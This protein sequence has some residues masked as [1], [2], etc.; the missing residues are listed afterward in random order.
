MLEDHSEFFHRAVPDIAGAVLGMCTFAHNF[1]PYTCSCGLKF[2]HKGQHQCYDDSCPFTW[3][4]ESM[5]DP[6]VITF[7]EALVYC[8]SME[9][10]KQVAIANGEV[11]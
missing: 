5:V 4:D 11:K 2:G 1:E 9:L 3:I 8:S 7:E 10:K 6:K